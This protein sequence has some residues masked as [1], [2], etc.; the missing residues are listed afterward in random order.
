[1]SDC[2]RPTKHDESVVIITFHWSLWSGSA[3]VV[4]S[5]GYQLVVCG[6]PHAG[7]APG[8]QGAVKSV[9]F[10]NLNKMLPVSVSGIIRLAGDKAPNPKL[11]IKYYGN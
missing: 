5:S 1:M 7:S 8:Q 11:L 9:A 2:V 6:S 4:T 3:P 10:P